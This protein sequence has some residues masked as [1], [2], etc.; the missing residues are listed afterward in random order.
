MRR[1]VF[2]FL[3]TLLA[4]LG[5]KP[6]EETWESR[7]A[8]HGARVRE[9]WRQYFRATIPDYVYYD[10]KYQVL[11]NLHAKGRISD[12][13]LA[14]IGGRCLKTL[15][16]LEKAFFAKEFGPAIADKDYILM[17]TAPPMQTSRTFLSSDFKYIKNLG[18]EC[19]EYKLEVEDGPSVILTRFNRIP[20]AEARKLLLEQ[21]QIHR[22]A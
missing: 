19:W 4:L 12:G 14:K 20:D 2:L 11:L 22:L 1:R 6:R 10:D 5:F 3:T 18:R 7:W 21:L 15:H 17:G 9:D 16:L 8:R 13:S